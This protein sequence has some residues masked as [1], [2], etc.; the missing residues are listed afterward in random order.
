[1]ESLS[2]PVLG[3]VLYQ[4]GSSLA[5]SMFF[6]GVTFILLVA[7]CLIR[8]PKRLLGML[9]VGINKVENIV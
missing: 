4:M 6:M 3:H 2:A 9:I 8:W 5:R 1:M 7:A